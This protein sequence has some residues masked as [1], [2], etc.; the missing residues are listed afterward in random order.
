[1][2]FQVDILF[3]GF[4][5]KLKEG[6]N[7]WS[8]WALVRDGKHNILLETGFVGLRYS[9]KQILAE[10]GVTAEDID[11]VLLTHTHFDHICNADLLPNATFVLSRAE[12]E[13]AN[14]PGCSDLFV[15]KNSV[16]FI[17]KG[18]YKLVDDGDE[19]IPGITAM[20]TPGHTPGCCSYI[21]DQ[22]GGVKWV[23]SGDAAKNRGELTSGQIQMSQDLEAS[24]N[25]IR[26]ILA[27][28][29]RILPGHDG[30]CKVGPNGAITPE[31]GNDKILEF[32]QGIS[33]NGGLTEITLRMD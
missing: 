26:R 25:S 7:G 28:G 29:Y 32:G 20:L 6:Y 31:G 1:M 2:A 33:I 16:E 27:A 30:W 5:G 24:C 3:G 11:I 9:Y 18:K 15:D 22:G 23:F 8:T 14:D 12:W 19:I 4:S 13:Y 10:H 21:L 17:A